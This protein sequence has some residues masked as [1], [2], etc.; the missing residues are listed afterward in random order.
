MARSVLALTDDCF[1]RFKPCSAAMMVFYSQLGDIGVTA[2][3]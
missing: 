3:A 1:E 2:N